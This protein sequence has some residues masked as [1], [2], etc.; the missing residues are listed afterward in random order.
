[1]I[2]ELPTSPF[3]SDT[4]P[5]TPASLT[6]GADFGAP[7]S[8]LPGGIDE[9]GG[10]DR[11][12]GPVWIFLLR[13]FEQRA[14]DKLMRFYGA[15]LRQD[16]SRSLRKRGL[17]DSHLDDI[18][19]ETW[20]TAVEKIK[21]F[22]FQDEGKLY[23]WLRTI[24]VNHI[25]TLLHKLKNNR[26]LD[27]FSEREEGDFPIDLF[28]FTHGYYADGPEPTILMRDMMA[29][30]QRAFEILRPIEREVLMRR[31]V[32]GE[33]PRDMAP[34]Y[35]MQPNSISVMLVRSIKALRAQLRQMGYKLEDDEDDE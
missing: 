15:D 33:A 5:T 35:G 11:L 10:D 25:R 22:E 3:S 30:V 23:N 24:S 28:L 20:L 34:E 32:G 4:Q 21:T 18:E 19:Q 17:D 26:S 31:I 7:P 12:S 27:E 1:M 2:F 8:S 29:A 9:T 6:P 16:I 14:W 13:Q